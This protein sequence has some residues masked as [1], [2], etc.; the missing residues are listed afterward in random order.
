MIT[1]HGRTRCQMY[2]GDANWEFIAKVK[3]AVNVPVIVNG[4]IKTYDCAVKARELS[5][6]DGVMLGRACYGKPWLVGHIGHFL[7]TGERLDPPH[8]SEIKKCA[9]LHLER[10]VEHYGELNGTA[11]ARKHMAWYS[12]GLHGSSEFR[13]LVN[14]QEKYKTMR[15]VVED[16]FNKNL[17]QQS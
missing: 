3:Q 6:A 16:F 2:R 4:D 14:S 8:L 10:N 17:D 9:L 13:V 12:K 11:I 5:G 15:Q 7:K 1:I